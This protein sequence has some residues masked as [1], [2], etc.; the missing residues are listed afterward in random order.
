MTARRLPLI[1]IAAAT[2]CVRPPEP[3]PGPTPEPRRY[4]AL[5]DSLAAG[6]FGIPSYVTRYAERLREELAAPVRVTNLARGGMRS[7][8]LLARLAGDART[9][10]A[11]AAA[12]VVT[13]NIGGNDL[14]AAV[15]SFRAGTCAAPTLVGCVERA[16]GEVRTR[17]AAITEE[18]ARLRQDT[19]GLVRTMND[20]NPFVGPLGATLGFDDVRERADELARYKCA[21]A[22]RHG[23][24]C[25]DVY[26][27]FN[28]PTG[29]RDPVAE[30][31]VRPGD[32]HPTARGQQ[33]MADAL[34]A[35]GFEPR[36]SE[37]RSA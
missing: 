16:I 22:Q 14:A 6:T 32:V 17:W 9:R 13:W 15:R 5:G 36:T 18:I 33:T 35:L 2:A 24:A 31:L 34:A 19:N 26:A 1:V 12:D 7:D 21:V 30:G 28:G 29:L 4:V 27:A 3:E 25:A 23:F 37:A 8:E 11:V 10:E 20:Y